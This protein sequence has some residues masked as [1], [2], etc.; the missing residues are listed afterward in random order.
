MRFRAK[1]EL[2]GKTAT[3]MHVPPEIVAALGAGKRPPVRATINGYTYRS[4][5][6]VYGGEFLL[7]VSDEVRKASGVRAGDEL[8]VNLELDTEPREVDVPPD[9]AA[10][11]RAAPTAQSAFDALSYSNK[12]RHVLS[13][14][15]AKSAE[16]RQRRIAKAVEELGGAS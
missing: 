9:L 5:V 13:V 7:G 10:A 2:A 4:T 6:A 11:L 12:R 16:T 14:D 3:G 1:L 8:D 15:G